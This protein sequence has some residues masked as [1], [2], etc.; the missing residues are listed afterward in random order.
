MGGGNL[1]VKGVGTLQVVGE[2]MEIGIPI[3]IE[4]RKY[5]AVFCYI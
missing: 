3:E 1:R 4:L 2:G 5:L